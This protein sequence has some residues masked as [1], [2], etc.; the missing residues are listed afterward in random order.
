MSGEQSKPDVKIGGIPTK[1]GP[2]WWPSQCRELRRLLAT[3]DVS[4][5]PNW[6]PITD[7]ILYGRP[8][9]ERHL[10]FIS[11]IAKLDSIFEFGPGYGGLC[12]LIFRAGFKGRYYLRDFP[13]MQEIQ[14]YFLGEQGLE[15]RVFWDLPPKPVDLFIST[16]ALSETPLKVREEVLDAVRAEKYYLVFQKALVA[17]T[18]YPQTTFLPTPVKMVILAASS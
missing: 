16:W 10:E 9:H 18:D 14:K 11:N 2:N 5:F 3:E 12:D 1:T 17:A 7:T 13:E 8:H 15:G 4:D 6:K